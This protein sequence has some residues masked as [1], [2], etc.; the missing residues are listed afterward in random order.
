MRYKK[1]GEGLTERITHAPL[2]NTPSPRVTGNPH[3]KCEDSAYDPDGGGPAAVCFQGHNCLL[4]I[5][6][7]SIFFCR[8][9]SS[10]RR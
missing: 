2:E 5:I 7:L 1:A 6:H 9:Q 10:A 4:E 8:K 3:G